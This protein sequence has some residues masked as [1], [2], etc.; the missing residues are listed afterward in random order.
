MQDSPTE[1][2]KQTPARP[3]IVTV[4]ERYTPLRK[5]GREFFGLAPCHDDR[6]PSL[7]VNPDKQV[8]FCDPCGAGGDVIRF[9]EVAEKVSFK[10]A[11]SILG[12]DTRPTKRR[13]VVTAA[14]RR[15]AEAAAAWLLEQRRKIN[16][17][18]GDILEEIELADEIGNSELAESFLREQFFLRDLYD[19][20]NIAR[21]AADLLSIRPMIEAITGGVEL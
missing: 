11:L 21:N 18:L 4:I 9:I 15:A 8:W 20:L 12:L 13:P 3:D 1:L 16:I 6:H 19:D 10:D 5:S 2:E 14:Q 7:R 17:L